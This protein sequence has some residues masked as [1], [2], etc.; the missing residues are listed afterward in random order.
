MAHADTQINQNEVIYIF[1]PSF[2]ECLESHVANITNGRYYEFKKFGNS[3]I[4]IILLIILFIILLLLK[5]LLLFY[6]TPSKEVKNLVRRPPS[7]TEPFW[8]YVASLSSRALNSHDFRTTPISPH[9]LFPPELS[10]CAVCREDST[11]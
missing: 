9:V 5:L 8:S 10:F 6:F 3:Y 4:S 1:S 7:P 11:A 2:K